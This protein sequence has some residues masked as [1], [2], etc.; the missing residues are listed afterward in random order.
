MNGGVQPLH[1]SI[2]R[3]PPKELLGMASVD[4][5]ARVTKVSTQILKNELEILLTS[6]E[7][8]YGPLAM[9]KESIGLDWPALK[10]EYREAVGRIERLEDYYLLVG[11]L[12][13]RF[14][15]AHVSVKLP[16]NLTYTLPLQFSYVEGKTVVN[17]IDSAEFPARVR[18]P[19][20]GMN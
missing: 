20:W 18:N 15:D 9:K 19:G 13:S 6:I 16:S 17:F 8:H 5:S 14:N 10:A 1:D 3:E 7:N 4:R 11:R 2:V 12:L